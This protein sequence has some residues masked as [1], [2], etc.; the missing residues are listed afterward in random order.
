MVNANVLAIVKHLE[1]VLTAGD[2]KQRTETIFKDINGLPI[3]YEGFTSVD[4]PKEWQVNGRKAIR[5]AL[6]IEGDHYE[7]SPRKVF[8]AED[9]RQITLPEGMQYSRGIKP[10]VFSVGLGA[11]FPNIIAKEGLLKSEVKVGPDLTA[12][13]SEVTAAALILRKEFK[14]QWLAKRQEGKGTLDFEDEMYL[15]QGI[16]KLLANLAYPGST[17][18]EAIKIRQR[19]MDCTQALV[20]IYTSEGYDVHVTRIDEVLVSKSDVWFVHEVEAVLK[21]TTYNFSGYSSWEEV[22]VRDSCVTPEGTCMFMA[23]RRYIT[24]IE[25]RIEGNFRKDFVNA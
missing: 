13:V 14:K 11:S 18:E 21:E 15:G 3:N 17:P 16:C 22:M 20:D 23:G 4:A 8:K 10:R 2:F 5:M 1:K 6:L 9:F 25:G 7:K 24:G 12:T 19:S